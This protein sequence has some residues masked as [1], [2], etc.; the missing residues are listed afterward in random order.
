MITPTDTFVEKRKDKRCT[1]NGMEMAFAV[2]TNGDVNVYRLADISKAGVSFVYPSTELELSSE[3]QLIDI[4]CENIS[5]I[6]GLKGIIVSDIVLDGYPSFSHTIMK[7]CGMQFLDLP[8]KNI[9]QLEHLLNR[10]E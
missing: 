10:L 1:L 4:L 5:Y 6:K 3:L 8:E 9:T 2:I 7:R